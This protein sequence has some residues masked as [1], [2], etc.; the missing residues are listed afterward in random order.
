[1]LNALS[2]QNPVISLEIC[3]HQVIKQMQAPSRKQEL[4]SFIGM[5]NY[6]SK[7]VPSMFDLTTP[8]RKWPEERSSFSVDRF[9]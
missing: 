2:I 9:P 8:L 4:Q 6:L 3:T 1:M 5:I 7:V